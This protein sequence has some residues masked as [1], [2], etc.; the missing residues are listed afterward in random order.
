VASNEQYGAVEIWTARAGS[1]LSHVK[2]TATRAAGGYEGSI[3]VAAFRGASG[4]AV[5]AAAGA[6][7]APGVALATTAPGSWVWGVG[8]DWDGAVGRT[9]DPGQQLVSEYVDT[10]IGDTSWVQRQDSVTPSAG[11]T[12]AISDA[13]PVDHQWN[14]AAIEIRPS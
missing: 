1:R 11:T 7:S 10:A 5:A 9:V 3:T 4:A 6:R 14:L 12:V 13:G 8:H 2:V